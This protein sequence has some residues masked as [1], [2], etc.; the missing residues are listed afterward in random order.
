MNV[1]QYHCPQSKG[2]K[3]P[4][5]RLSKLLLFVS[6]LVFALACNFITQPIN[7]AQEAVE[8]VQSLATAMPIETLRALPSA[9]PVETL[10]AISTDFPGLENFNYF[11]PQGTPI[12]EW[13]GLPIMAQATAGQEF[14]DTNTYSFKVDATPQEVQE[15]YNGQLTDLGWDSVFS[16]P[17]SD[18]GGLLSFS[19]NDNFLTITISIVEDMTIVVISLI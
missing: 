8:T 19:N 16:L 7:D 15:F 11:D 9:L 6:L 12:S 2:E 13:M 3:E 18:E 4:M 5:S 14:P 17:V 1:L 10:E